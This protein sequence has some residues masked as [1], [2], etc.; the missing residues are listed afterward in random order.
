MPI[1]FRWVKLATV[2]VK[3]MGLLNNKGKAAAGAER[4]DICCACA[5]CCCPGWLLVA[6]VTPLP[7]S[8][9]IVWNCT[10]WDRTDVAGIDPG[11]SARSVFIEVGAAKFWDPVVWKGR[12]R[13]FCIA[14]AM[15]LFCSVLYIW[16]RSWMVV[17][18]GTLS[19]V[20]LWVTWVLP[21]NDAVGVVMATEAAGV[22]TSGNVPVCNQSKE[23]IQRDQHLPIS[24][25]P[26]QNQTIFLLVEKICQ[27]FVLYAG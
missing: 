3:A 17:G 4:M 23:N 21:S 14:M 26:F 22:D 1:F 5:P 11:A 27:Y 19:W 6:I 25:E 15:L 13:R 9:A 8:G 2:P 18:L 10:C 24:R 7:R 16:G 20:W 12:D